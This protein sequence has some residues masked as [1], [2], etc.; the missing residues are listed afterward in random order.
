MSVV[1]LGLESKGLSWQPVPEQGCRY[2]MHAEPGHTLKSTALKG[3]ALIT[4]EC[5]HLSSLP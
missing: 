1:S 5:T 4:Q 2:C 3:M